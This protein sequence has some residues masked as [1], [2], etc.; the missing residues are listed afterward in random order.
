M[1][2]KQPVLLWINIL[3][4]VA[5]TALSGREP[6][7]WYLNKADDAIPATEEKREPQ[8]WYLNKAD[9][10]SDNSAAQMKRE[11]QPWYL[12]KAGDASIGAQAAESQH[13]P[14]QSPSGQDFAKLKV[15]VPCPKNF[16]ADT[17]NCGLF[18]VADR[19][20][21]SAQHLIPSDPLLLGAW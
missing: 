4:P 13:Q 9:D 12:N 1:R 7:P 8:P 6:Q 18:D 10:A 19:G 21:S 5:T 3:G 17:R 15:C 16:E 14:T 20:S 2:A 11:P